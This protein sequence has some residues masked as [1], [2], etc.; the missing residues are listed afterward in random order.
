MDEDA[1]ELIDSLR[2]SGCTVELRSRMHE[3]LAMIDERVL[4]H[5]SLNILS[6]R[7]T[8]ES[9]LRLLGT[10]TCDVISK[11]VSPP[12]G[13]LVGADMDISDLQPH[14]CPVP[15]CGG[16]MYARAGRFG[17]FFGCSRYRSGCSHTER[18]R[19]AAK[20]SR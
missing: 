11:A 1:Q 13:G 5:G 6:H 16:T 18:I 4:W 14:P 8:T 17:P 9:M 7:D 12:L 3:K 19:S 10:N 20:T 2:A 15:G